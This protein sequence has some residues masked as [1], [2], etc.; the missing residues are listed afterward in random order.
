MVV[1]QWL[2]SRDSTIRDAT[3]TSAARVPSVTSPCQGNHELLDR[4]GALPM[5]RRGGGGEEGK[6]GGYHQGQLQEGALEQFSAGA[7][8]K[9]EAAEGWRWIGAPSRQQT[10]CGPFQRVQ[11]T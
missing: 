1:T 9:P 8:H 3:G 10:T 7:E 4:G 6:R 11:E 2:E 5:D